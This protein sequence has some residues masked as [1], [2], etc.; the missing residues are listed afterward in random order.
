MAR[1]SEHK[2]NLLNGR[3]VGDAHGAITWERG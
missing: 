3:C 2:M 1:M